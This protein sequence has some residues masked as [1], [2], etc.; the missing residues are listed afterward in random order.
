[1]VFFLGYVIESV[2]WRMRIKKQSVRRVHV[3]DPTVIVK[4]ADAQRD[5]AVIAMGVRVAVH[6]HAVASVQSMK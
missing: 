3:C 4:V 1:M 2:A 6:V 5:V